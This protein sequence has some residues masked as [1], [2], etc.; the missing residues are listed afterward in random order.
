MTKPLLSSRADVS[1]APAMH[2]GRL[3]DA[4]EIAAEMYGG[5]VTPRWVLAH[6]APS[7]K[8]YA[9]RTAVWFER[10]VRAF[11][12][13]TPARQRAERASHLRRVED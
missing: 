4:H 12:E 11:L 3:M 8:F 10:D 9:G 2:T 5:K 13:G 1:I 6:V 7:A